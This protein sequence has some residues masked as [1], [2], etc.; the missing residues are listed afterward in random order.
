M[1]ARLRRTL[2]LR[3]ADAEVTPYLMV[4]FEVPSGTGRI[5]ISYRYPGQLV[6]GS[7][8][9]I[10]LGL[11]DHRGAAFGDFPG[12]R[13]WSGSS[14]R[15]AVVTARSATPGYL[16]GPLLAGTWQVILGLVRVPQTGLE[17]EVAVDTIEEEGPPPH[18]PPPPPSVPR[19]RGRAWY[20]GDLHSHT[21]HSDAPGTLVQLVAA[22]RRRGLDFLAVTDHNTLSHLP[23]LRACPEDLL[24]IPGE[25][26]TNRFGHMTVLGVRELVDFRWRTHEEL[27]MVIEHA[28]RSGALTVAAHPAAPE[29]EWGPGLEAPVDA[30]EV[31]HGPSRE[32]NRAVRAAWAGELSRDRRLVGVGGSDC[33]CGRNTEDL[34]HPTTWVLADHLTVEGVVEG[35]RRGRVAVAPA[36]AP[37]PELVVERDGHRWEIGDCVPPGPPVRVRCSSGAQL[38]TA[39]GAYPAGVPLDLERHRY[40]WAELPEEFG[41]GFT[42]PI[43]AQ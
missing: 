28:R 35:L 40:V 2:A 24:L 12:F 17:V 1:R 9:V 14:R 32:R 21:H 41:G 37:R 19:D 22:A 16:P 36:G 20:A 3:P 6:P 26:V 33:H 31:W 11:A 27:Q 10:D 8:A 34:G 38:W 13:G 18:R 4:P 25:E 39:L 30:V 7:P 43:R 15:S 23:Y 29:M 42:N 5:E